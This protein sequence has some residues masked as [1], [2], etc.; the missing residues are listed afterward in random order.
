MKVRNI[1]SNA[2]DV[3]A[4]VLVNSRGPHVDTSFFYVTGLTSGLF[5]GCVAILQPDH[6][7]VLSSALEEE[8][9]TKGGLEISVFTTKKEGENL[10]HDKLKDFKRIGI[11]ADELTYSSFLKLKKATK[12]ELVDVSEAVKKARLIKDAEEISRIKKACDIISEVVEEVPHLVKEGISENELAAEVNYLM[13]KKGSSGPAFSSLICF[14][15]NA[16]E[17]H[18]TSDGTKLKKGD[19]VLC[20]VGAEYK[21]YVSDIT[22]TFIFGKADPEQVKMYEVVLES[23]NLALDMLKDGVEGSDVH[24][25]V[26]EF[27]D[28]RYDG[29]FIHGLG[30]SIGLSVHDGESMNVDATFVFR[31][32]MVFTVEPGVYIPGFG[33]VRIEDDVV[34]KKGGMEILTSAKKEL[35]VIG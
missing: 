17:P 4:I 33:G 15:K 31:E 21:K 12:A 29:R 35:H 7:E 13:Q 32:G 24:T 6:L 30:H 20:D 34:I 1:F 19:F 22:R 16:S 23:Q 5:E 27:L 18:H 8:S 10:L 14:G 11:N 26:K 28:S 2:P 25:K 9:A 3:D